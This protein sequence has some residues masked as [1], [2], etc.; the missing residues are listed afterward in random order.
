V[1]DIYFELKPASGNKGAVD[2]DAL[3]DG[4]PQPAVDGFQLFRIGGC[5]GGAE[6]PRSDL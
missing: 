4:R 5:G 6:H 3:I 2:Y 1:A